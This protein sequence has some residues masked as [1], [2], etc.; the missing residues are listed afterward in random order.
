MEKKFLNK[1]KLASIIMLE[2]FLI[3]GC[4]KKGNE[5]KVETQREIKI[6]YIDVATAEPVSEMVA[7]RNEYDVWLSL[8]SK[9][10]IGDDCKLLNFKVDQENHRI[11]LDFNA[12]FGDMIRSFGSTG[13]M[14]IIGCLVNTYL[15][16]Y[17][18]ERIRLTEEGAPLETS[19]GVYFDGYSGRVEF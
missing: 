4:E 15:D 2:L 11:D 6:Y 12:E 13:E 7:I 14:E 9:G 3:V 8:Q 5:Q 17:E 1:M 10:I 18:C 19:S 16:A